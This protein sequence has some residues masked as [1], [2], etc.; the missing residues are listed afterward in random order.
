M[1]TRI[2][3]KKKES[4]S[5]CK[6][7]EALPVP[8][9]V[10]VPVPEMRRLSVSDA[11]VLWPMASPSPMHDA[12]LIKSLVFDLP[13]GTT[14]TTGRRVKLA[15]GR[16]STSHIDDSVM[17]VAEDVV[18]VLGVKV[19]AADMPPFMQLHAVRCARRVHDGMDRFSPRQMAH[20]L[21]KEFDKVYGPI[22]HCVVGA[23]FG[24]FVTHA[25]GCFLYFSMEKILVMLFKTKIRNVLAS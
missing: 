13:H 11:K 2:R 10:P 17:D 12:C 5:K 14:S 24:S 1:E 25:T 6:E 7:K 4:S 3:W 18:A 22:W 19:I 23:S 8:V 15:P 9:P 21:K 16:K 20:D